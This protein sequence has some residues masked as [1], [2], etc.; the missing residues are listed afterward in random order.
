MKQN[1]SKIESKKSGLEKSRDEDLGSRLAVEKKINEARTA[2]IAKRNAEL[3]A[4]AAVQDEAP[5]PANESP[6]ADGS[7]EAVTEEQPQE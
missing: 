4:K 5:A 6:A 3:A 2:R 1:E 7:A